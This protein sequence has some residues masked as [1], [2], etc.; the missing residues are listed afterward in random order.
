MKLKGG[1]R[2]CS[3]DILHQSDHSDTVDFGDG[4]IAIFG[5]G[6]DS[7]DAERAMLRD[8]YQVKSNV[9]LSFFHCFPLRLPSKEPC[10]RAASSGLVSL[11]G[12]LWTSASTGWTT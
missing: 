12:N 2:T 4:G 11:D 10:W 9:H 6:V 8:C 3:T 1:G 7:E 5:G